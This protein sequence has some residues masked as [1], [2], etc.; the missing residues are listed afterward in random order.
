MLN[1]S[2]ET[3][4]SPSELINDEYDVM[5]DNITSYSSFMSGISQTDTDKVQACSFKFG[6][7]C[8]KCYSMWEG[9]HLIEGHRFIHPLQSEPGSHY[10][11]MHILT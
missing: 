10:L 5:S 4:R 8:E 6:R 1:G 2:G 3:H 9:G 11:T 7:T